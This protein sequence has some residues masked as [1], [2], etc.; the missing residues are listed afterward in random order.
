MPDAE[1]KE[2]EAV[3]PYLDTDPRKG[4][5][6]RFP[7]T[8][9]IVQE[10]RA[11]S[12]YRTD[13]PGVTTRHPGVEVKDFRPKVV[14]SDAPD[15]DT[16]PKDSSAQESAESSSEPTETNPTDEPSPEKTVEASANKASGQLKESVNSSQDS[17]ST[18]K[19]KDGKSS[20]PAGE[21]R[22]TSD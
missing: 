18:Q 19:K 11:V 13:T 10:P 1:K 4:S 3:K 20:Q 16:V 6:S 2:A 22:Q 15:E 5:D 21:K 12:P 17:S 14:P 7:P 9:E 8:P